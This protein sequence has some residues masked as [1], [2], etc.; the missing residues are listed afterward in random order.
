MIKCLCSHVLSSLPL[1]HP[2]TSALMFSPTDSN[3]VVLSHTTFPRTCLL[4]SRLTQKIAADVAVLAAPQTGPPLVEAEAA[5]GR[6]GRT[7]PRP[8]TEQRSVSIPDAVCYPAATQRNSSPAAERGS[9]LVLARR[10]TGVSQI[11]TRNGCEQ[12]SHR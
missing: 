1:L 7:G 3:E 5:A 10:R 8:N 11:C 4:W 12:M 2:G 9:E 6:E